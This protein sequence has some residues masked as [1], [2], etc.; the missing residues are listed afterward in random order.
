MR[1]RSGGALAAALGLV[2]VGAA[3]TARA[4]E[5][6]GAAVGESVCE[7]QG[8]ARARTP[9]TACMACH[10]GAAGPGVSFVM[11]A[12]NQPGFDHPVEIDYAQASARDPRLVPPSG[13]PPELVL[14][15]G[16][17]ACTTCHDGASSEPRRVAGRAMDLC[18]SC[19][20]M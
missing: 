14:V 7:L 12:G 6:E 20:R 1:L 15:Q 19:H 2:L 3:V 11:R 18:T 5:H 13:L 17:L 4:A 9:S 8:A 10:D 16:R